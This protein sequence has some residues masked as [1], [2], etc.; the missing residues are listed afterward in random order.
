M[1]DVTTITLKAM[2]V[3]EEALKEYGITLE[4]GVDDEI[5]LPM[6]SVLERLSNGNYRHE[7]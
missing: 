4:A 7:H 2:E 1:E 3:I 6:F 5:Y